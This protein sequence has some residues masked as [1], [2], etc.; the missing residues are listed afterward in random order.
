MAAQNAK[1]TTSVDLANRS[2]SLTE[3]NFGLNGIDPK[4]QYI[5]VMDTF[6]FYNY[7][8][9][10]GK[11]F[12]TIV[13]DPPSFARNKKKTFSVQKNY[14]DLINGA[15]SILAPN[16]SLLLCTNSSTFSLKAFKM[17]LKQHLTE[18]V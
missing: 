3:E 12:D 14:D 18:R 13:I 2:R 8:A 6:D 16:G 1:S 10:H 7:A 17:L 9:R 15:L 5:Y 11:V 4:S